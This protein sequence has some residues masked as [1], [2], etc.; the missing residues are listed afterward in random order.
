[1]V[2]TV[3]DP[4][5]DADDLFRALDH[6]E[7]WTHVAGRPATAAELAE[8]MRRRLAD[9]WVPWV[10]RSRG[11]LCGAPSGAVLGTTSYLDIVAAD[12]RLEIGATA[13][14]PATWGTAVNPES[15]LLLLRH[16][17]D[18]LGAG[19]VQLKT[20]IR[21]ERAQRAIQGIGATFEG[22]LRRYQRRADGTIRD[23]VLFSITAED[24]PWVREHL[25]QRLSAGP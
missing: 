9:G 2:L 5:R 22:V 16:A 14:A 20:D 8:V 21:N 12:A 13:Y 24:W 19:R 25:E 10:V 23:T 11:D 7:C 3:V 15:K 1:M 18:V 6:D 4:D 17:F